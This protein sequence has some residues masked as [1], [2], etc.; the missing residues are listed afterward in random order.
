MAV[1]NSTLGPI[2]Q[3]FGNL[4]AASWKGINTLRQKASSVANPQTSGQTEQRT[5]F[6]LLGILGRYFQSATAIGLRGM[7]VKMS[8]Y[9]AFVKYNTPFV[10]YASETATI[11]AAEIIVSKG[12][13]GIPGAITLATNAT[14][15]SFNVT[16][17][18]NT[19]GNVARATDKLYLSI[20]D[21]T[22]E[23]TSFVDPGK[24]RLTAATLFTVALGAS[25]E[26][27]TVEVYPFFQRADSS[28][29]GDNGNAQHTI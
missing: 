29:T 28:E 5:K 11:D 10:S 18:D 21:A 14:A 25:W 3:S 24:T 12:P 6:K 15:G 27:A 7:A 16:I 20:Y 22:N 2:K 26:G 4:T 19:D 23:R 17:A 8:Q 9:N 13:V 1:L